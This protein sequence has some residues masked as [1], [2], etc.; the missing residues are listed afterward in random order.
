MKSFLHLFLYGFVKSF[1]GITSSSSS[2]SKN[3]TPE[4]QDP[5][6]LGSVKGLSVY[7]GVIAF[8]PGHIQPDIE[9]KDFRSVDELIHG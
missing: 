1:K 7:P 8:F 6:I 3:P 4:G 5:L 9:A 2:K